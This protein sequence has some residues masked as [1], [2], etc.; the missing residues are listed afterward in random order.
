MRRSMKWLMIG[1]LLLAASAVSA[2][3]WPQLQSRLQQW[4]GAKEVVL[5]AGVDQFDDPLFAPVVDL[6]LEQG[7]AVLPTGGDTQDG[8]VLETRTTSRGQVLLLKRASDGAMLA[9]EKVGAVLVPKPEPEPEPEPKPEPVVLRTAPKPLTPR[10]VASPVVTTTSVLSVQHQAQPTP[11][12]ELLFE[13]DGTPLQ[14]VVWPV[15]ESTLDFYLMYDGYIQRLRSDNHGLQL[16]ERFEAPLSPL[17]ALHLDIGDLDNDGQPELAAVWAEDVRGVADGTNSLLHGWVLSVTDG[18]INAVSADLGGYVALN[19][20]NARLQKRLEYEAFA[21][22]VYALGLADGQV[23]VSAEPISNSSRLLFNRLEW[24]DNSSALVW[25]DEDR[26]MLVAS[27][28]N[29]RISGSTLLTDFGQYQ[30]PTV[31]IPLQEPEYL[32]GFSAN[33]RIMAREITLGRR[34]VQQQDAVFTIVRGRTPGMLLVT[35]DSG[36]DRLVK[37]NKTG[38]GLSASYPF[39]AI[40]AFIIDFAVQGQ[41]AVVLVNEKADGHGRAY[42]RLQQQL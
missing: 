18:G 34:M 31:S 33:D 21:P 29:T 14:M 1:A 41:E 30:G 26:L 20:N 37:I 7:F 16:L 23:S 13:L 11:Q 42:L 38:R 32:S 6:L 39:A 28:K 12:G 40:D 25:N 15:S 9:M 3:S 17:R 4:Q 10:I 22:E 24:P 36:A 27:S 35:R 5:P 2:A 8:L 19:G